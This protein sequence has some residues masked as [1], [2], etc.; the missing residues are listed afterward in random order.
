MFRLSNLEAGSVDNLLQLLLKH[1]NVSFTPV[2]PHSRLKAF[3]SPPV[4]AEQY[5]DLKDRP[6]KE[7]ICLFDV[8]GTL[9]PARKH[10]SA[11]MLKLLSEL[12]HK[13]VIGFV[14]L[15][16]RLKAGLRPSTHGSPATGMCS[17]TPSRSIK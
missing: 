14:S 12:R 1:R 15:Y 10:V 9:T 7:T 6:I 3:S 13:C 16:P 5:P 4:M 11:E 2:S 8:D 17:A